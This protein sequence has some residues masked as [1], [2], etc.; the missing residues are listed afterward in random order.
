MLQKYRFWGQY[1]RGDENGEATI[2][3]FTGSLWYFRVEGSYK[4]KKKK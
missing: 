3:I 2:R 1:A 4:V